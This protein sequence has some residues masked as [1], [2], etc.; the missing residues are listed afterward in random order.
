MV[1]VVKA[2][3]EPNE[4]IVLNVLNALNVPNDQNDLNEQND[5]NDLNDPKEILNDGEKKGIERNAS[6]RTPSPWQFPRRTGELGKH[7][8]TV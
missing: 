2:P 3:N 4:Y 5:L 6:Y 8:R 7:A 1:G